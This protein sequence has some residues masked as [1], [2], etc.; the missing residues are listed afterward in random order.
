MQCDEEDD[1]DDE[2]DV[3]DEDEVEED[4][5]SDFPLAS[6]KVRKRA[7]MKKQ[8]QEA[9]IRR[10]YECPNDGCN[11]TC[12]TQAGLTRHKKACDE[13]AESQRSKSAKSRAKRLRQKDKHVQARTLTATAMA[14]NLSKAQVVAAVATRLEQSLDPSNDDVYHRLKS[15]VLANFAKMPSS[16]IK[17]DQAQKLLDAAHVVEPAWTDM[18]RKQNVLVCLIARM[19]LAGLVKI[20]VRLLGVL[21]RV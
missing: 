11:N 21:S 20:S 8:G 15:I 10:Q 19:E 5:M 18:A 14:Q 12:A 6:S 7:S 17:F 13:L 9:K 3:D 2:D 16:S 4:G 1:E